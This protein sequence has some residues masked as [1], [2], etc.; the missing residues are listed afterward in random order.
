MTS[1]LWATRKY[2]L[3]WC[4]PFVDPVRIP[5]HRHND[6]NSCYQG[7]VLQFCCPDLGLKANMGGPLTPAGDCQ[8]KLRLM[9]VL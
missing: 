1:L 9:A 6:P 7:P 2:Q 4:S 3:L 8:T 5:V